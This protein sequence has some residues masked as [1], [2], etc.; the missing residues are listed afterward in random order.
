MNSSRRYMSVVASQS[1]GAE[2]G[3][4]QAEKLRGAEE[5]DGARFGEEEVQEDK[6]KETDEC[7]AGERHGKSNVSFVRRILGPDPKERLK[8]LGSGAL[9]SYGCVSN[10]FYITA[11]HVAYYAGAK[12]T[13]ISPLYDAT[14]RSTFFTVYAGLFALNNVL[15]PLRVSLS[16]VL[17]VRPSCRACV[18]VCVCVFHALIAL[19]RISRCV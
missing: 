11:V 15:R 4:Y 5:T 7:G 17:A 14:S 1:E 19:M 2:R 12:Q 6:T 10:F 3:E 18:C 9:L 13:G 8:A 16:V